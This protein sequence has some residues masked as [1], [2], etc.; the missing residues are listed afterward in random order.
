MK[1][2]PSL[3]KTA[4]RL[5]GPVLFIFFAIFFF[6]P[7]ETEDVWWHLATGRWIFQHAQVPSQDVF[8]F[9]EPRAP[10]I[11]VFWL[12]SCF[13]YFV[14]WLA[15]EAGLKIFRVLFFELVFF[16]FWRYAYKKI[17]QLLLVPLML[18]MAYGL[19]GRALLRPT[20]FNLIFVQIFLWILYEHQEGGRHRLWVLPP[21]A[22]VWCNLHLGCFVY[23][24][25]LLLIFLGSAVMRYL[26]LGKAGERAAPTGRAA[27]TQ[28]KELL[29]VTVGFLSAFFINPYGLA[30]AL[31]P[32][33]AIFLPAYIHRP[34]LF[35]SIS[36]LLP[37][38]YL[39][40][41]KGWWFY[42]LLSGAGL[43]L[44]LR[45]RHK[46]L[47]TLLFIFALFFFL[48]GDRGSE[49]FV[50]VCGYLIAQGAGAISLKGKLDSY[51]V[52]H[53]RNVWIRGFL[54][55][56]LMGLGIREINRT[57]IVQ[58]QRRRYVSMDY[59]IYN[60]RPVVQWFNDNHIQGRIFNYDAYGGSFLWDGYPRL[61][62]FV[63]DRQ[64]N[65]ALFAEYLRINA[66]PAKF[67]PAAEKKYDFNIAVAAA[68]Q[69]R[70]LEYI[71]K[72]PAWQLVFIDGGSLVFVK[73]GVFDMPAQIASFEKNLRAVKA[74]S[75]NAEGA[76][77]R[78]RPGWEK[79]VTQF[80]FPPPF[81][82]NLAHE[83]V[84]LFV[85]G[86]RGAGLE[87]VRQALSVDPSEKTRR[88]YSVLV[89]EMRLQSM[90]E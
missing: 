66:D 57:V 53:N 17:P 90:K 48:Y 4:E 61:M 76:S 8:S 36:E 33:R 73:K 19:S 59:D 50:V 67:W 28:I 45:S 22:V 86:Y 9:S 55:V 47:N 30:G 82:N 6:R 83:G 38:N 23:G 39:L 81:Y 84:T 31:Y 5:V 72:R 3:N 15:H 10:W 25:P 16:L 35:N 68:D 21:A 18:V 58:G 63:D 20:V 65:L 34:M 64:V 70:F 1:D 32:F 79:S 71:S 49:F 80:F 77:A 13:Y 26:S 7:V 27:L 78:S 89:K 62:P 51:L 42:F 88:A 2:T 43:T 74:P 37:P 54:I 75:A 69:Y 29:W 60:V 87:R 12:G 14:Y 44:L 24:F 41:W 85:L 40:T 46:F 56:V 11:C 52:R